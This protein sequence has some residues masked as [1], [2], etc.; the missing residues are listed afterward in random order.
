MKQIQRVYESMDKNNLYEK[1]RQSKFHLKNLNS[2][3]NRKSQFQ[4]EDR[5]FHHAFSLSS[6]KRKLFFDMSN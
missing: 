2:I 1:E 6:P 3:R 4:S 5:S